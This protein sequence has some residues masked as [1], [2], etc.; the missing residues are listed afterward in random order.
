MHMKK[1]TQN[2]TDSWEV[3]IPEEDNLITPVRIE[4]ENPLPK[5]YYYMHMKLN[6]PI[7]RQSETYNIMLTPCLPNDRGSEITELY[8]TS[9]NAENITL[10][11]LQ[12]Y[13]Q[14][15]A[16]I[17]AGRLKKYKNGWD[18]YH[19]N[20]AKSVYKLLESYKA[21]RRRMNLSPCDEQIIFESIAWMQHAIKND[22]ITISFPKDTEK[23]LDEVYYSETYQQKDLWEY[24]KTID[25]TL[26][27]HRLL[28]EYYGAI[29]ETLQKYDPDTYYRHLGFDESH[30]LCAIAQT[31]DTLIKEKKY[32]GDPI[33]DTER[34][35]KLLE[36]VTFRC[37]VNS[38]MYEQVRSSI[39]TLKN[40]NAIL[41]LKNNNIH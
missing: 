24:I 10:D 37:K 23:L 14:R 38:I 15:V 29:K 4:T 20:D 25:D 36:G 30:I 40:L 41:K 22:M 32:Q 35:Y 17:T 16:C 31:M 9:L 39:I 12:N 2:T 7:Y 13:F 34:H 18:N 1:C 11:F 8:A 19:N 33:A 5:P 26:L 3:T 28:L 21:L 27:K 6:I